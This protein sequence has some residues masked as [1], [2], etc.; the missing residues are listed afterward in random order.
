M[1]TTFKNVFTLLCSLITLL[2]I[3]NLVITFTVEKPTTSANEEKQLEKSDLPEVAVCLEP[4]YNNVTLEKFGYHI[5]YVL[6]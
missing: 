3:Y 2:L 1:H 4:G 6:L 5:S